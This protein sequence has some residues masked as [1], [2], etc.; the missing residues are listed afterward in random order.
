MF[1]EPSEQVVPEC[2]VTNEDVAHL[3]WRRWAANETRRRAIL[4][5]Y[6]VDEWIASLTDGLPSVRHVY[7]PLTLP[8]NDAVFWASTTTDWQAALRRF[9]LPSSQMTFTSLYHSLMAG[10]LAPAMTASIQGC[11]LTQ[12][13]VMEGLSSLAREWQHAG[14]GSAFGSPT[15]ELIGKGLFT[16]YSSCL[17]QMPRDS[18]TPIRW[19]LVCATLLQAVAKYTASD[20]RTD[21]RNS[22]PYRRAILHI[23]TVRQMA[24]DFP[25]SINSVPQVGLPVTIFQAGMIMIDHLGHLEKTGPMRFDLEDKIDWLTLG[26]LGFTADEG[27]WRSLSVPAA[28]YIMNGG[29][30]TVNGYNPG[31]HH[32]RPFIDLLS[33]FG[34]AWPR[35]SLMAQ[36][37]KTRADLIDR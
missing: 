27:R 29:V 12:E 20:Q 30:L 25:I 1:R 35:C 6:I 34:N 22:V 18:P 23:N 2:F 14:G 21:W 31:A 3:A 8:G 4:A 24:H 33:V 37:L 17:Q 19:H 32:V 13:A 28:R 7:N 26:D 10:N 5:Y 11:V 36:E 9:P 15:P 16:F